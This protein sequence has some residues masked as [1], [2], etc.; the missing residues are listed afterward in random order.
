MA[1]AYARWTHGNHG[2][3][4]SAAL[5]GGRHEICASAINLGRGTVNPRLGCRTVTVGGPAFG[6][7]EDV[8]PAPGEVQIEA[9]AIDP[10]TVDPIE[11]QVYVDDEYQMSPV[12]DVERLD[13]AAARPGFGPNH[14]LDITLPVASG[15]RR[16][17]DSNWW[18]VKLDTPT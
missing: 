6:Q 7:L 15:T 10:D 4:W 2:F 12:A 13:V 8:T 11:I 9:W 14:G 1:L 16:L 17:S 18:R 5:S 3:E